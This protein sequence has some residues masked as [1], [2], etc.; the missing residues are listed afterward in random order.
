M[1]RVDY[2]D[3]RRVWLYDLNMIYVQEMLD[4]MMQTQCY[5]KDSS[6]LMSHFLI[7]FASEPFL[8]NVNWLKIA[9]FYLFE[10]I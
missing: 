9:F 7:K 6:G 10:D 8:K 2:I 3:A 5:F 1:S 4:V